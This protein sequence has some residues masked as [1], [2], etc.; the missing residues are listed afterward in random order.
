[1]TLT[2]D[3]CY[4][5]LLTRDA[6][7]DGV[8]FVGVTTTGIY[9]RPVCTARTPGRDR[10]KFFASAALAEHE[11]FR[12]CLRCRPELAPGLAP[13]DA[14]SRTARLAAARIEAG[15]LRGNGSLEKLARELGI[16]SRQLRRVVQQ[17][18]G[19]SPI[20]LAQTGRLL[21]AKQLL[22]ESSLPMI[23]VA[24]ASGF[25][26]VRRFNTLVR[27]H[28]GL[29]PTR[30]RRAR[31]VEMQG[32][33]VRL[34]VG[35]R[36]P[37][38]WR[39]LLRFLDARATPGVEAVE[40]DAYL[41]T[42][43]IGRQR[44]WLR[45]APHERPRA[46]AVELSTSL[47]PVLPDVLARVKHSFDLSARPDVIAECLSSHAA[48]AK[49]VR[50]APGLRVPGAFD[51][52]ELAVRAILGQQ[53]SVRAATTLAGRLAEAYGE[54]IETP[55]ARLSRMPV[56]AERL[57]GLRTSSIAKLGMRT[58]VAGSI[59]A[60]AVAVSRKR[61]CLEPGSDPE[62]TMAALVACPGIGPWTAQYIAMRACAGPTRFPMVIW[63][64]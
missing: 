61:I 6:R 56:T 47:L 53:I 51:G 19:V 26:S 23:A 2:D 21:L 3:A 35:Y 64:C 14:V 63:D 55:F 1:M 62:A 4:R 34:A 28:Y 36:P 41:R 50:L 8:F 29:T 12:P 42:V 40:G 31:R 11:G 27:K 10:C 13:I 44:G 5:V 18:F 46:L 39:E 33:C 25:E 22:A 30:M 59:R 7:F 48:L 57:A 37:M 32:D 45:V 20:Q 16:S 17:E 52:F 58:A 60:L 9:C 43:A 38:A 24:E 49:L 15:V 54:S